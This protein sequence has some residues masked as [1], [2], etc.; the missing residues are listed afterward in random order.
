[1]TLLKSCLLTEQPLLT[2]PRQSFAVSLMPSLRKR[3]PSLFA[4]LPLTRVKVPLWSCESE[5]PCSPSFGFKTK[6]WVMVSFRSSQHG[7]A[8]QSHGWLQSQGT[9]F[10]QPFIQAASDIFSGTSLIRQVGHPIVIFIH[11]SVELGNLPVITARPAAPA[12]KIDHPWTNRTSQSLALSPFR[13]PIAQNLTYN[14][15]LLRS[16]I[17]NA[18]RKHISHPPSFNINNDCLVQVCIPGPLLQSRL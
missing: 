14:R 3:E 8:L 6:Q 18:I 12:E 13:F 5:G 15:E 1:M 10:L 2:R 7:A 9:A 17:L 16:A 4:R 11:S